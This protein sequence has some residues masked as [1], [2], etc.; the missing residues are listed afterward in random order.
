MSFFASFNYLNPQII[1]YCALS[2]GCSRDI[3]LLIHQH[4][5][6]YKARWF[7]LAVSQ[8]RCGHT[9]QS[10]NKKKASNLHLLLAV[11]QFDISPQL[12]GVA[13]FEPADTRVK[14]QCLTAW[15]YPIDFL[16]NIFKNAFCQLFFTKFLFKT[17][18]YLKNVYFW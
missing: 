15:R 5:P 10:S 9:T 17:P 11:V 6:K 16:H 7:A 12:A 14:V 18:N 1:F 3:R 2:N 8:R 13:G 4:N